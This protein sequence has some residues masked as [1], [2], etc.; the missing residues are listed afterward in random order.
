MFEAKPKY[1]LFTLGCQMNQSDAERLGTIFEFYGYEAATNEEEAKLVAVVACSIR[2]SALD[3]IYG[4]FIKKKKSGQQWILTGCL[5]D[6]DRAKL[7]QVFDLVVDLAR[8]EELFKYLKNQRW[9]FEVNTIGAT[10]SLADFFRIQPTYSNSF[11]ALVPI[12]TGCNNFCTYCVVPYTRGREISRHRDEVMAEVRGL[13]Q[14]GYKEITLL[15][16]NVNSYSDDL[17]ESSSKPAFVRLLEEI[18]ALPGNFWLRFI[19]SHPKDLSPELIKAVGQL[20]K[21]AEYLHLPVQAGDDQI[22]KKMNRHYTAEYY[23]GLIQELRQAEPGLALSTDIIVGFPGETEKQFLATADLM[24]K[25]GYD[26]AYLAEFS[27]RAGTG[28][29]R[30]ADDVPK[31]EKKRR[32]EFLNQI[33]SRSALRRNQELVGQEVEVLV[34]KIE[35]EK[36]GQ[37]FCFGKTRTFKTVKFRG[38]KDLIGQFVRIKISRARAFG[39]E[40]SS[41]NSTF[42]SLRPVLVQKSYHE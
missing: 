39:L 28:A 30:L 3:R 1:Y 12:M 35:V 23:L 31:E 38:T 11:S 40:G 19:T 17:L 27:P 29:A 41:V 22:L 8:P 6:A 9:G 21:L 15:G 20:D 32:K 25:V 5:L 14:A 42:T 37:V 34:D 36:S 16:Q 13:V 33:L 4:K 2:Q 18:N 7:S 26:M 24:E 10:K